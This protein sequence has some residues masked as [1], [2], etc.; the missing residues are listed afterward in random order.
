[1][2]SREI[3]IISETDRVMLENKVADFIAENPVED[4]K[5]STTDTGNG[6]LYSVMLSVIPNDYFAQV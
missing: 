5:F 3:K 2:I 4:I 6:I 1:M